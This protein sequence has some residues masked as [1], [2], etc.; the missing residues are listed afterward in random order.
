[1]VLRRGGGPGARASARTL[2]LE[3]QGEIPRGVGVEG[4][5]VAE[6]AAEGEKRSCWGE[7]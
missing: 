1:M 2:G 5:G 7:R 6:V 3:L 4:A